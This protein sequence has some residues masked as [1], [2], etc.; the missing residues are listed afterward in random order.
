MSPEAES[1][2]KNARIVK[3][4]PALQEEIAGWVKQE[5]IELLYEIAE[6]LLRSPH[7]RYGD[8][9]A[10]EAIIE[11]I[12]RCLCQQPAHRRRRRYCDYMR[13]GSGR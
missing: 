4:I 8:T 2:I 3:V 1:F 5:R 6:E 11:Q 10:G 9:K 13:S 12:I 7:S